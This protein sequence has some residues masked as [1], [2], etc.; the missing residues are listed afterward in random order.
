MDE[1]EVHVAA[2]TEETLTTAL[3]IRIEEQAAVIQKET[4]SITPKGVPTYFLAKFSP[5]TSLK[6][7]R[8]WTGGG[9]ALFMS[10]RSA[11]GN[12]LNHLQLI[13]SI[14]LNCH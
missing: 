5:Q 7:E 6:N 12:A 11:N 1:S 9:H 10:P 4:F 13:L 14:N 8:S 2:E 3:I